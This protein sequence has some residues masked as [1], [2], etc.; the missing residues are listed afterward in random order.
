[1]PKHQHVVY[2]S[3]ENKTV[4]ITGGASGIGQ[5]LV[6][7]FYQQGAHVAFVDLLEKQGNDLVERLREEKNG[8]VFFSCLDVCDHQGLRE[9][10]RESQE[11]LGSIDVLVNNV[12]NDNRHHT[13][14]TSVEDWNHCL[15]V[16][17]NASF[18]AAQAVYPMMKSKGYGSIVNISSINALWGPDNMPGYVTAKAK[19]SQESLEKME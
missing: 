8:K 10:I 18:Y 2:P 16:N 17:L 19:L 6:E 14:E 12:A 5:S 1:M 15:N 4:F 9:A 7:A 13:P 3:L 11:Q